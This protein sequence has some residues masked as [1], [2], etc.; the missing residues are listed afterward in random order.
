MLYNLGKRIKFYRERSCLTQ[1]QLAEK[2]GKSTHHLTQIERGLSLP[3]LPMFYNICKAL[4][5]P[6]DAF[7]VDD[8]KLDAQYALIEEAKKLNEYHHNDIVRAFDI[9]HAIHTSFVILP[10]DPKVTGSGM[11]PED[12]EHTERKTE[13]CQSEVE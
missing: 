2:I 10:D 5:V 9:L 12:P 6:A 7:F 13:S 4:D 1:A 3:S 11:P 8:D